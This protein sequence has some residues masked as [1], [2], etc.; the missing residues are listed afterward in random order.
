VKTGGFRGFFSKKAAFYAEGAPMAHKKF[1]FLDQI[2]AFLIF[3][4]AGK[5]FS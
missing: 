1:G 5:P 2:G 4:G 3:P